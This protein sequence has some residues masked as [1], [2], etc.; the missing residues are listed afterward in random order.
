MPTLRY[1]EAS[2][3]RI[4]VADGAAQVSNPRPRKGCVA[5]PAG[6]DGGSLRP[7]VAPERPDSTEPRE[8]FG[9]VY[10]TS[11]RIASTS[12]GR[13]AY[14]AVATSPVPVRS[15]CA[16]CSAVPPAVTEAARPGTSLRTA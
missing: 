1:G 9:P 13:L 7:G 4:V 3:A 8:R 12:A 5:E 6:I 2:Q 11:A 14:A 10:V 15:K 16:S